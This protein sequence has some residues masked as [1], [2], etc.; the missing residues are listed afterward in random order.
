MLIAVFKLV[1]MI[2]SFP[3]YKKNNLKIF[4]SHDYYYF[5]YK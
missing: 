2:K 5:T 3:K 1:E 4:L